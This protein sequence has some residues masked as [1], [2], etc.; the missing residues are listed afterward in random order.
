MIR[1]ALD[2]LYLA[3]GVLAALALVAVLLVICGQMVTRWL[4]IPFPGSTDYAGYCMARPRS[5][6]SPTPCAVARTFASASSCSTLRRRSRRLLDTVATVDRRW[7]RELS[8]LVRGARR[9]DLG[10]LGDVS[11][12][13][14]AT[15]L[16]IPQMA[17]A[18]GAILLAVAL[19]DRLVALV[20]GRL[21]AEEPS[22][23]ASM[24]SRRS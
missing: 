8:R 15:P 6:R 17:M 13:Q 3:A 24:S 12:G 5:W 20:A 23:R 14:D 1:R 7:P 9:L 22:A 21:P 2:G 19:L 11:Q 16:W 18:L 4:G 10:R